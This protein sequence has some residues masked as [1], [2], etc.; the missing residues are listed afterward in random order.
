MTQAI[1]VLVSLLAGAILA[2]QIGINVQLRVSLD[3]PV[4]STLGSFIVGAIGLFLYALVTRQT[5]PSAATA[6]QAPLWSWTGGLFGAVY[7]VCTIFAG[8]K[9]GAATLLSLVVAGQMVA[10]IVLDHFGLVGFAQHAVNGWRI[11]G[12]ALLIGGTVLILRN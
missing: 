3:N 8:P 6:S 11:L 12:A 2:V 5:W 9:L 7:I 4:V 10:A 1:L